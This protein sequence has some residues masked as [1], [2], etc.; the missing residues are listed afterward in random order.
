MN[1]SIRTRLL[2]ILAFNLLLLG[3]LGLFSI[4]QMGIMNDKASLINRRSIPAVRNAEVHRI[5]SYT[6]SPAA[7]RVHFQCECRRSP[8]H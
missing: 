3:L 5:S 4:H 6:L 2:A 7:E 1:Y 8:T